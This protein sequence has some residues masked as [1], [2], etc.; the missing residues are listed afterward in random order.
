MKKRVL[1]VVMV[2]GVLAGSASGLNFRQVG[3]FPSGL[4]WSGGYIKGGDF[5]H[6]GIQDLVFST[7][8]PNPTRRRVVYYGCL[9]YNRYVF[10]DTIS[11]ANYFWD[12]GNLDDDSLIDLVTQRN[13]FP[14]GI[15][16]WEPSDYWSFPMNLV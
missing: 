10:E 6:N 14:S 4:I 11:S 3:Y 15:T 12:I 9:P 1:W 2:V 7:I 13:S 5:N 8:L 16:V